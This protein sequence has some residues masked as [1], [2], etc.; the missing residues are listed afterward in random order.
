MSSPSSRP[1]IFHLMWNLTCDNFLFD[2]PFTYIDLAPYIQADPRLHRYAPKTRAIAWQMLTRYAI[3][4]GQMQRVAK[5]TYE[6]I[7][8]ADPEMVEAYHARQTPE[9]CSP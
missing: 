1:P 7:S 9:R 3:A 6:W 8:N 2:E 4:T 5:G